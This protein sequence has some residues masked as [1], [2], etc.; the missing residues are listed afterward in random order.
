MEFTRA[1]MEQ[2]HTV[3]FA[4]K[5]SFIAKW[6]NPPAPGGLEAWKRDFKIL[7]GDADAGFKKA[8]GCYNPVPLAEVGCILDGKV[9]L[10]TGHT[11][12]IWLLIHGAEIFP[13]SCPALYATELGE[14]V[15][16]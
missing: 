2:G 1:Q 6:G 3:V 7:R 11:R 13:L 9:R 4:N 16:I 5:N 10:D 12:T 14:L 8:H 15:G